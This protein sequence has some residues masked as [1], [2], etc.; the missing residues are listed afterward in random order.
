MAVNDKHTV[1]NTNVLTVMLKHNTAV[2][3]TDLWPKYWHGDK[4]IKDRSQQHAHWPI[5]RSNQ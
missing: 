4:S 1:I 2:N 3:V 5:S